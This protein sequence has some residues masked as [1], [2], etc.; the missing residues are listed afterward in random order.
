[1]FKLYQKVVCVKIDIFLEQLK[2]GNTY[3]IDHIFGDY[4]ISVE[5]LY[6]TYP[7]ECFVSLKEYRKIKLE[8]L[9]N[10]I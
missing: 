10:V 3:T 8:K 4:T 5:E 1:M 2:I 9:N 7:D 6:Y